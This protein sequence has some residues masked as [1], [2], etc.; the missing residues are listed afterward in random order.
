MPTNTNPR[1]GMSRFARRVALGALPLAGM[2]G[3]AGH[4]QA[5]IAGTT[6]KPLPNVLLLVDTSGSMERMPDNTL[7]SANHN[8]AGGT[9]ITAPFNKCAPGSP[10]NPNRW[11][12]LLQALTGNMQPY[13]SCDEV[14][15][16]GLAFK[17]EFK[18]AGKPVYDGDYF[19]PYHRPLTGASLPTACTFAPSYLPGASAGQ[20]VG[21]AGQGAGGN[22]EDFP[23][24]AF[25]EVYDTYLK[26]Q[27]AA[28][29]PLAAGTNS[30]IF[31]QAVDG[32]LD[33]ARD[34]VR[35]GLM[36][37]DN[38]TSA[39]TGVT[40]STAIA[41][42]IVDTTNPFLGQWS[43][44]GSKNG[45]S[46][47]G[48]PLA[49]GLPAGCG[50]G[51]TPFEVG[52]RHAAAPPWEGRMVGF[53]PSSGN[54]FDVE[55]TNDQIQKVLLGT[56]PYGATPIEGM[57]EDARDYLLFNPLGPK[58]DPYVNVGCRDQYIVLLT[59][60]AP[61]LDLRPSCEGSGPPLGQCPFKKSADIARDLALGVSGKAVQTYVIGFS[62]NGTGDGKYPNDGFPSAPIVYRDCKSWYNGGAPAGGAGT[63]TGM[64]LA[65]AALGP[66]MKGSTAD[67]CC[68]LN[69]I[70]YWGTT[71]NDVG[72]FFAETQADLVLSFGRI[73]GGV[74]KE[75]TTRTLP[76]YAPAITIAGTSNTASY[77]ASFIPN[78]RKVWSGEIDRT[79]STCSS[80][81]VPT[82]QTQS[83]I[84]GDSYAANLATQ[85]I[86]RTRLF[87]S[88]LAD[89]TAYPAPGPPTG[90]VIDSA[91]TIRPWA[92]A[93]PADG[94]PAFR[95]AEVSAFDDALKSSSNW[96]QAM[97]IAPNG[98]SGT[99]PSCKHSKGILAGSG[100]VAGR[101]SN[102]TPVD[103]PA[104][105]QSDCTDV[106]WGFE[107]AKYG[108]IAPG[109]GAY[110]FNVRCTGAVGNL[111]AGFC[112]VTGGG[113][114]V[115][116]P[117]ACAPPVGVLGEVCV[118]A[119]SAL[120]AIYRS[121]PTI[122]GT[123]NQFLRDNVYQ[124]FAAAHTSRRPVMYVAS[125]DGILHAFKA[126]ANQS[127][128][129]GN[130]ELWAFVPPA[131]LPKIATNYPT[132]Q[133]ILL[134]S[135]PTVRD[136][137][138]DRPRDIAADP[139]L[140]N[141]FHT[142][143]V[144][145]MGSGGAG[146]YALNVSDP[147]CGGYAG[148]PTAC[149]G[150]R[151]SKAT[152][153]TQAF[154]ANGP[155]FLWQLTDL[156]F[157]AGDNAKKS[158]IARDGM[159]MVALFGK[160]SGQPAITT[161][162]V[163]PGDGSGARQI[164]VAILPGG[165]DGPPVPNGR[166]KR[167]I[168]LGAPFTAANY[169]FSDPAFPRRPF[170]RQWAPNCLSDAVPGRSVTIV[171]L[172]TGEVLRHFG[173]KTGGGIGGQL[174]VPLRM[175]A[176][177]TDSPFDSP[178]IGTPAVYPSII[179]AVAQK[180]FV[181]DADGTVWRIDVSSSSPAAWTVNLFQDLVNTAAVSPSP[182]PQES[183]PISTP[184]ILSLDAS[185]SIVL[186]VATGD[187]ENIVV[188]PGEKNYV[189]SVQ[190][191]R[192]SATSPARATVLWYLPLPLLPTDAGERVTGP[193]TVF[194]RTL[195]FATYTPSVP[196]SSTACDQGGK[197]TLWGMDYFNPANVLAKNA[198]GAPRWCK[199]S[200]GV[201]PV[202]GACPTALVPNEDPGLFDPTL[203]GAIIP[204]VTIKAAQSCA[205]F[206]S[207]P[208]DPNITNITA[209]R[210]DIAFGSTSARPS[211]SAATGTPQAQRS[212]IARPLPRTT[213][214]VD[215]WALVVD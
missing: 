41:P 26:A 33:A 114:I 201:D 20:G 209:T 45:T 100:T 77:I 197:S 87:I 12:M 22:A 215:A 69:E 131:V 86:G 177:T 49:M 169:D 190:E 202:T 55:T 52:A 184:P 94:I 53:A 139:T 29:S 38:D 50:T 140:K 129:P 112:S 16:A 97:D 102:A 195:Y 199:L 185:G 47:T 156:Q 115:S 78:A 175:A 200:P 25:T 155:H 211:G 207:T 136:T 105:T 182:G 68:Q 8:P 110:D 6:A 85:A 174:D 10:T 67:A 178:V 15:R 80:V 123:P 13:Y 206:D 173:R 143:L 153:Q 39:A 30:C 21:P 162:Q 135:T 160:E 137:V 166:C 171:R 93:V 159:Q 32:Q 122:V 18:I 11:G 103:I 23:A 127:F 81:A 130:F 128:D 4:A 34:Y 35:F 148:N 138:W 213:A 75:A 109:G 118:P 71:G 31:E 42:T 3:I 133:Q 111:A 61:N 181:G 121:S 92:S 168:D 84:E 76:G 134:D 142:T 27:Y 203:K 150:A 24:N 191:G 83:V 91:R 158:R 204:G 132:G 104:L 117:A 167:A 152:T 188:K 186:N 183:Q 187:Q 180:I 98:A 40:P 212:S 37:F 82:P 170:V 43:Y 17:N 66:S 161:L 36:T 144:A 95:G 107:T 14:D 79:R 113:C 176:V 108:A 119:C 198:G 101:G 65:C 145:G 208:G 46:S 165:I 179:G 151:F 63:P 62:V 64:R 189:Y 163:D 147:D 74:A 154:A 116:D 89:A 2:L 1:I 124:A 72:P 106:M 172:D 54:L 48:S 70:A 120:G 59:D 58:N 141:V 210:F 146:Y 196:T 60:G 157:M 88:V 57:L 56:R 73:L 126:L 5:Q 7:P 125:A 96:A 193:M 99:S 44:I 149:Q 9:L 194:D 164:G 28:G 205:A 214:S 192:P 90:T 19:L 51:A